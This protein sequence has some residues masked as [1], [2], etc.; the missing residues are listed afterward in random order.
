MMSAVAHHAV[1]DLNESMDKTVERRL[2][3]VTDKL[4]DVNSRLHDLE[5]WRKGVEGD[6]RILKESQNVQEQK[7]KEFGKKLSQQEALNRLQ[8]PNRIFATI[9][10]EIQIAEKGQQK[11]PPPQLADYKNALRALPSSTENYWKTVAAVIN[12]QS[13]ID[14]MSGEAPDPA[15]VSRPCNA[16]TGG[17]Y[18]AYANVAFHNCIVDLDTQMFKNVEFRNS[19][20][21]YRGGPASLA[22][23]TFINC[24]FVLELAAHPVT[25][26]QK[27]LLL[28]LLDSPDQKSVKVAK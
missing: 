28:A 26:V 25:P 20:I 16:A 3:P 2:N 6:V 5:G 7:Q 14:Q 4:D 21:R 12:Y 18:N 11:L 24:T 19:V 8:D 27:N 10:A 13:L 1:K 17:Y 22:N 9:R 23:V 15:Q